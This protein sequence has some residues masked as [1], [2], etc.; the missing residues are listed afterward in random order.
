MIAYLDL[1][2]GLSG[3]MMLSCLVDAGWA[4]DE[5]RRTISRLGLAD[6][7][8]I[9]SEPTLKGPLRAT[10]VRVLAQEGHVHRRLHDVRGVIESSDLSASIRERSV[11]VFTRLAQ[12]EAKVHGAT[13]GEVH[14]HEVGAVDAIIDVVGTVAGLEA[15][16]VT[17]LY[18]SPTPTGRGWAA[19][20]HGRIPLP[21][22]AVLELLAAVNAPTV[23]PPTTEEGEWLTPTG[24]ALLAELARFEQPTMQ[25]HRVG[26]GA[27][28]RD[29]AVPNVA[30]LI[31]GQPAPATQKGADLLQIQ[32][33]LDDMN[34]QL[35]PAV[36]TRLLELGVRD[37]WLSAVQMKKGR[38]GVVLSVLASADLEA[39]VCDL[40]L[41]H[42]STLGVRVLPVLRRHEA[43]R[44]ERT[45]ATPWGEVP[46]KIKLLEGQPVDATP[47]YEVCLALANQSGVPC[48]W[49]IDAAQAAG[50]A[51]IPRD[52]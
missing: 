26:I 29:H 49:V 41:R 33:N 52:G 2:C 8:A 18:A 32:T 42:T 46:V 51:L 16:G 20:Q 31:L 13:E 37:V 25:L 34:P 17:E 24:A 45:V 10:K 23:A 22:P 6:E 9:V 50:R 48:K 3:D 35:Y 21:A 27:G 43:Q 47:E 44:Q 19:T 39:S 30:R 1:P 40:L 11:A 38:P 5:L 12:A 15:L 36:M 7:W 14:F 28:S 4:V